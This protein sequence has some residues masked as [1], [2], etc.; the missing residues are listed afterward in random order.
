MSRQHIAIR[1]LFAV[2][3][4]CGM[5][6]CGSEQSV[7]EEDKTIFLRAGDFA[8]FGY[9]YR[10]VETYETFSKTRHFD[11]SHELTYRFDTP[12]SE[13]ERPLHI[14][15][16]VSIER[17][18]SDAILS[19]KAQRLGL[20][21]GFRSEGAEERELAA[22]FPYGDEAR[23]ALLIKNDQPIGNTFTLRDKERT[24]LLVLSGLYFDDPALFEEMVGPK[25]QRFA[26]YSPR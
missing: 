7:T 18:E 5:A 13:R 10:N 12:E 19:Q 8:G 25:V 21:V 26:V 24:Y 1:R 3:L 22:S 9:R 15:I 17:R 6:A 23:L 11:G 14:Y 16:S 20:L 4:V 2:L